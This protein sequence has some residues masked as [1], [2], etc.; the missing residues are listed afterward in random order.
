M[1][2]YKNR[3]CLLSR[4]DTKYFHPTHHYFYLI[5]S[6]VNCSLEEV[7][8]LAWVGKHFHLHVRWFSVIK[9]CTC[10]KTEF[11]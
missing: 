11:E 8:I 5:L 7:L 6:F 2:D 4:V 10:Y 1:A 3:C 9:L